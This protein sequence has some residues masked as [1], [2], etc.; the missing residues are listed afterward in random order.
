MYAAGASPWFDVLGLNAPGYKYPPA[1]SPDEAERELG[2]RWMVFRHVED[3]RGI[4]VAAGDAHK[5]VALLEVGW[6]TTRARIRPITGML[7]TRRRRRRIWWERTAMR[8]NTGG[9]G[10]G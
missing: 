8:R 4:M 5:Q 1:M 9:P 10:W 6:T 3:M 2:H 7:W